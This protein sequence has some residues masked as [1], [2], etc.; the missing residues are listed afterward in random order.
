MLDVIY[1]QE[2]DDILGFEF[3]LPGRGDSAHQISYRRPQSMI[4]SAFGNVPLWPLF[5]K[6]SMK[7]QSFDI[8]K[9]TSLGK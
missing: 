6:M 5:S 8:E 1:K 3:S 9:Q 4:T 7:P 2:E